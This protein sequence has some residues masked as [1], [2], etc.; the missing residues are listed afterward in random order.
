VEFVY[1]NT[2][3][4]DQVQHYVT[5]QYYGQ[6]SPIHE[7]YLTRFNAVDLGDRY[8][9]KVDDGHTNSDWHSKMLF[10][11]LKIGIIDCYVYFIQKKWC[12]WIDFRRELAKQI[13]TLELK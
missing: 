8:Y 10:A 13:M 7:L 12:N 2:E 3:K 11:I 1:K 6:N 5:T 9:A 4:V